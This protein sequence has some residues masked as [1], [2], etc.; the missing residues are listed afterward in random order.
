[1]DDDKTM[2]SEKKEVKIVELKNIANMT[3]DQIDE[4]SKALWQKLAKV[5]IGKEE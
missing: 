1:M 4:Y 2:S 5:Q 3:N